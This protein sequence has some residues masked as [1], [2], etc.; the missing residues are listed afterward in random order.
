M[1]TIVNILFAVAMMPIILNFIS[2]YFKHKEFGVVDNNNPRQQAAGLSGAGSRSIAAQQN[3]W[4]ALPLF[5]AAILGAYLMGA[6]AD[7]MLL[8]AY[9]FLGMRVAHAICYLADLAILRSIVWIIG[10]ISCI[11]ILQLG[12]G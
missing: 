11:W 9:I 7:Q 8:P 2:H 6:S 3:A 1:N 5:S 4:E 12:A 10:L